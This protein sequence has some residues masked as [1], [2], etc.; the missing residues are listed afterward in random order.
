MEIELQ[1]QLIKDLDLSGKLIEEI[2][3]CSVGN[4][5]LLLAEGA[6][7]NFQMGDNS[8]SVLDFSDPISLLFEN[9]SMWFLPCKKYFIGRVHI[10]TAAVS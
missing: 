7:P 8:P 2:K 1:N 5:K 10:Y 9:S 3:S 4:I 6:N